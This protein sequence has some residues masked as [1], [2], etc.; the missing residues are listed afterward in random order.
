MPLPAILIGAGVIGR[1]VLMGAGH[2]FSWLRAA[3]RD[4]DSL[5]GVLGEELPRRPGPWRSLLPKRAPIGCG[6]RP[7]LALCAA[8]RRAETS[9]GPNADKDAP[10]AALVVVRPHGCPVP[11]AQHGRLLGVLPVR[12]LD[13]GAARRSRVD[14]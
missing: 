2:A 1:G 9:Q 6:S 4:A 8:A 7:V 11:V 5:R 14:F 10:R 13:S 12:V 3:G